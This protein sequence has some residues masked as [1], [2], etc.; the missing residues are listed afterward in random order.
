MMEDRVTE[1]DTYAERMDELE[2]YRRERNE[3]LTIIICITIIVFLGVLYGVTLSDVFLFMI[4]FM[5]IT[6]TIYLYIVMKNI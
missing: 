5:L 1:G 6:I 2:D 4:V 3:G